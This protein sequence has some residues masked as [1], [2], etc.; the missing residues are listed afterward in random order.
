[1]RALK[2]LGLAAAV[3]LGVAL[4]LTSTAHAGYG[5]QYYSSWGYSAPQSYY[6]STYYYKPYSNYPGYNYNYCIYYPSQPSYVYYYNPYKQVYWGRFDASKHAYSLLAEKDR[7][8]T[9]KEIPEKAFP[10]AGPMP[11]IPDSKDEV[12]LAEPKDLP[13]GEVLG[14]TDV[15]TAVRAK[16]EGDDGKP[17]DPIVQPVD[18]VKPAD[19][20]KPADVQPA[21]PVKPTDGGGVVP[22]NPGDGNKPVD[23]P[24]KPIDPGVKPVDPGVK[25]VD[26]GVKP[27]DPGTTP[28]V[29]ALPLPKGG[30]CP[31][32]C[33]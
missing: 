18:S 23:P 4:S 29:P 28:V 7:S 33:H 5:R 3:A 11:A 31:K 10:E 1:M 6:Y 8:G 14:K 32:Q 9:L 2:H 19:G 27:V 17:V 20:V 15:P 16:G 24:V 12:A 30:G 22:V 21:D 25:P 26:P 13:K